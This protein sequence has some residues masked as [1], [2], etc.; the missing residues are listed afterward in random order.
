MTFFFSFL[1]YCFVLISPLS[2][3]LHLLQSYLLLLPALVFHY[4]IWVMIEHRVLAFG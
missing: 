2:E 3:I 4:E 1:Y